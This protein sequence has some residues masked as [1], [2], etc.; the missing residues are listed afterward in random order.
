MKP[1]KEEVGRVGGRQRM[2]EVRFA[3]CSRRFAVGP[4]GMDSADRLLG[5]GSGLIR[6]GLVPRHPL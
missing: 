1:D 3:L 5:A 4:I 2:G 6:C